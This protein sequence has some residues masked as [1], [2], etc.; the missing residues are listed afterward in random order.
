[1][2]GIIPKPIANITGKIGKAA[3]GITALPVTPVASAVLS[4]HTNG[5]AGKVM[6]LALSTAWIGLGAAD[7]IRRTIAQNRI[8]GNPLN[9]E[10]KQRGTSASAPPPL[11]RQDYLQASYL[12]LDEFVLPPTQTYELRGALD[13]NE[14][15]LVDGVDIIQLVRRKAKT[16]DCE[17]RF[18]FDAPETDDTFTLRTQQDKLSDF[19]SMVSQ[20]AESMSVFEVS[21]A[22]I[23]NVFGVQYAIMTDYRYRENPGSTVC[24]FNFTLKE[25]KYGAN[26]LTFDA[27]SVNDTTN[28]T[29]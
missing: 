26:L 8:S 9:V 6:M 10:P 7:L 19:A 12:R 2:A 20:V 28:R 25:V 23:N 17:I 11:D 15:R 1:M 18:R 5:A 27:R 29:L 3:G 4:S 14:S 16:V 22:R 21:N 13:V 24:T